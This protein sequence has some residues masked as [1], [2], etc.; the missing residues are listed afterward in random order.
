MEKYNIILI[1]K[2][3]DAIAT[4]EAENKKQAKKIAYKMLSRD[5]NEPKD[6]S[7]CEIKVKKVRHPKKSFIH[8]LLKI[9]SS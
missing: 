7:R 6:P 2:I 8:K 1:F 9:I 5:P 4:I 3:T